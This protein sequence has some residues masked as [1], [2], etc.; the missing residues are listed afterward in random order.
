M[1]QFSSMI[2][3]GVTLVFPAGLLIL[4]SQRLFVIPMPG[5]LPAPTHTRKPSSF[6]WNELVGPPQ[7][8]ENGAGNSAQLVMKRWP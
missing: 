5:L 3:H 6:T 8:P 7:S 4:A 1:P 2:P